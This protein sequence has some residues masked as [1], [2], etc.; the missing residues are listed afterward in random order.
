MI[1]RVVE[2]DASGDCLGDG[3][4][5]L[6]IEGDGE[7]AV[8]GEAAGE[9]AHDDSAEPEIAAIEIDFPRGG[10]LREDGEA[11][12]R[13]SARRDGDG[14]FPGVEVERVAVGD[15]ERGGDE[16]GGLILDILGLAGA[17]VEG[18]TVVDGSDADR[19]VAR[20][21]GPAVAI[22]Q[23]EA[24]CAWG[25]D[26]ILGLGAEGNRPHEGG[27]R[28]GVGTRV[29]CDGQGD[30]A[31]VTA[32]EFTNR[33]T[34]EGHCL[35]RDPDLSGPGTY[36]ADPEAIFSLGPRCDDNAQQSPGVIC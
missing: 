16:G 3:R 34:C 32:Q 13:G 9:G 15:G 29:E 27:G 31:R 5:G 11:I 33:H 28:R 14:Q 30:I 18:G 20:E 17:G 1:A 19:A 36:I 2:A 25:G 24:D 7:G 10:S 8:G 35:S 6:G 23:H 22:G 12:G 21:T 4:G 26:G